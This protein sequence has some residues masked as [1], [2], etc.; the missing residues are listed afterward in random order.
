MRCADLSANR[1]QRVKDTW[2][3]MYNLCFKST[4][5]PILQKMKTLHS[6]VQFKT[7]RYFDINLSSATVCAYRSLSL[8][9]MH[10]VGRAMGR[11]KSTTLTPLLTSFCKLLCY[12]RIG[13]ILRRR[14]PH[15]RP[16]RRRS[17]P[18]PSRTSA[19][20][21]RSAS[22]PPMSRTST[23]GSVT[24]SGATTTASSAQSATA[25]RRTC[26][27]TSQATLASRTFTVSRAVR[28]S[29]RA[30]RCSC[31]S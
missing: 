30:R 26:A 4:F 2:R 24:T 15:S 13:S 8:F 27:P 19:R 22:P 1:S 29:S 12:R 3:Y 21:V 16:S 17:C 9:K 6:T 18:S 25:A 14:R 7:V 11:F 28:R 20:P 5:Q 31:T 10:S 23:A